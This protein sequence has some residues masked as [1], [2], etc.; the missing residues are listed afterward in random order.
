MNSANLLLNEMLNIFNKLDDKKLSNEV[1]CVHKLKQFGPITFKESYQ[2]EDVY[3]Y[4]IQ[5]F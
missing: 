5:L 3:E 4:L 1:I 2:Q